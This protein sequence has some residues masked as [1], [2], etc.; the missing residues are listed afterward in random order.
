MATRAETEHESC[1]GIPIVDLLPF[2][3]G[4]A[5]EVSECADRLFNAFKTVGFAYV[6]NHGVPQD[7]V[8]EAFR[9]SRKF[10]DLPDHVKNRVPHPPEGWYHRGY[11]GV[12]LEKATQMVFDPQDIAEKRKVPDCKESFEIGSEE[13]K[14]MPNIWLP[15]HEIPGFRAFFNRFY[16]T[17]YG[18]EVKILRAIALGMGLEE[19]YFVR[20]HSIHNNQLRLLHYPP[21]KD[22]LL[23][24]GKIESIGAHSDFGTLT[25]LFQDSVGG[26]EVEDAE[27]RGSFRP[28][29]PIPG[30]MVV[31]IGDLLMRWS[32]DELKSTLH[33]VRTPPR[34][35]DDDSDGDDSSQERM[36]LTRYSIPYF[37]CAD[38]NTMIDYKNN[39]PFPFFL[40]KNT[41]AVIM[42][43]GSREGINDE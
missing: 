34:I 10:F 36:T 43:R 19:T 16:K 42:G 28:A 7:Q 15:E 40:K 5:R 38:D 22:A 11:S 1:S 9:W 35:D 6:K 21:V 4:S 26:L 20:C 31:N 2:E 30:T 3:S 41:P 13:S 24:S 29:V 25:L 37:I 14:R 32:N 8:D 18:V 39:P 33:R 23:R 17:C 27:N 12:G